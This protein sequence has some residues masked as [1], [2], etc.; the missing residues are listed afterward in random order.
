MHT[1]LLLLNFKIKNDQWD[2]DEEK[3]RTVSVLDCTSWTQMLHTACLY[4]LIMTTVTIGSVITWSKY[5]PTKIMNNVKWNIDE[6]F[7]ISKTYS[8]A[9][10][11]NA[12]RTNRSTIINFFI[13]YASFI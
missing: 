13:S 12:N 7:D 2:I 3:C 6:L 4:G 11:S 5:I 8:I 1:K 9:G 10:N